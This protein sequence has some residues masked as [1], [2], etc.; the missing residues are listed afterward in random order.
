[1]NRVRA[2]SRGRTEAAGDIMLR[3]PCPHCGTR[4]EVEFHYG[5]DASV[6]RPAAD[7]DTAAYAAYVYERTNPKGWHRE[8]W[9]HA[10]GC[11]QWLEVRRHTVSHAI[12]SVTGQP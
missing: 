9:F 12:D 8:W 3:I 2:P 6:R 4:D 5:G 7:A 1:M 10:A 11:R